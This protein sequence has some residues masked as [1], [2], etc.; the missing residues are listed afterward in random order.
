M[1]DSTQV[2]DLGPISKLGNLER[3]GIKGT[4]V[5]NLEPLADLTK[6]KFLYAGGTPAADEYAFGPVKKNGT[7]VMTD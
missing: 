2:E 5:K 6:L 3:L 1:L 7:K 4:K